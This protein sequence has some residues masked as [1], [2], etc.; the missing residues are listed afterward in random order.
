MKFR[1][2]III[3]NWKM[4]RV[5]SDAERLLAELCEKLIEVK[6]VSI[7]VCPPF[8]ALPVAA[9]IIEK[10]AL[11]LGAQNM[12]W[13]PEGAFT[14]EISPNMLRDIYVTHVILGHS[15]RRTAFKETNDQIHKKMLSALAHGLTPILCVGE[16]SSEREKGKQHS[17]VE[18]QIISAIEN[19]D[20]ENIRRLVVAYE[21]VWAIGTGETATPEVAQE[22]HNAIRSL[23]KANYG[24]DVAQDVHIIYGGSM[25]AANADEL[26]R[27]R[28]IDGGLIGGAS[29]N[30]DEFFAICKCA[31]NF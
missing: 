19:I 20:A 24:E 21:P 7:V 31:A 28:D 16:T 14:G 25:K 29:L 9:T 18:K 2:P 8:V 3:G 15:E 17:A 6:G 11:Q 27:Q 22:M 4:N 10:T 5:T 30:A 1:Q 26:L 13:E 23:F 12:H